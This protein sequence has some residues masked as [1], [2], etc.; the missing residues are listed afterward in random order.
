MSVDVAIVGG[1]GHVGLPLGIAFADRGLKVE[2]VDINSSAVDLVNEGVLP[3]V[4]PGAAEVLE[5]VLAAERLH[6]TAD[7]AAVGRAEY[8]V[9]VIGTPIDE[10][11]NPDLNAVHEAVAEIAEGLVDGQVLVLRSTVYP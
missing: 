1:C 8:V 11:L 2:L 3:F 7:A 5:G 4:E 9:V 6:A 10:H